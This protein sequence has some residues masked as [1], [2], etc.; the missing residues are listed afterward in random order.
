VWEPAFYYASAGYQAMMKAIETTPVR[1]G[2]PTSGMTR[3][4]QVKLMPI[5]PGINLRNPESCPSL[6]TTG[7]SAR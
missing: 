6:A 7:P 3:I 4:G 5:S 1:H 2:Q